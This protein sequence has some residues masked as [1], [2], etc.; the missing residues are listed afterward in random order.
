[1]TSGSGVR[2]RTEAITR[3]DP[4]QARQ[5][6]RIPSPECCVTASQ[7]SWRHLRKSDEFSDPPFQNGPR[8]TPQALHRGVLPVVGECAPQIGA[9]STRQRVPWLA[10]QQELRPPEWASLHPHSQPRRGTGWSPGVC[11]LTAR[12]PEAMDIRR[13]LKVAEDGLLPRADRA[14]AHPLHPVGEVGGH[15]DRGHV[16]RWGG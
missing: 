8:I 10:A 11:S 13:C 16:V 12:L 14:V 4:T 6:L 1:M 5:A 9:A 3:R 15:L 2:N 7:G